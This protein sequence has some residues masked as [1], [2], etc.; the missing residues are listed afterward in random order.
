MKESGGRRPDVCGPAESKPPPGTQQRNE[1]GTPRGL[2]TKI[3]ETWLYLTSGDDVPQYAVPESSLGI[4]RGDPRDVTPH[5][6]D[7]DAD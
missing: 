7:E 3:E 1:K 2:S 4:R 6:R 5:T